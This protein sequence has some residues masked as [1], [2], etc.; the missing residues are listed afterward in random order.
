MVKEWRKPYSFRLETKKLKRKEQ[1]NTCANPDCDCKKGLEA[2]HLLP[3]SVARDIY[4]NLPPQAVRDINNLL[5]LCRE[6]HR[7]VH[8]ELRGKP[9]Q[10]E[11]LYYKAVFDHLIDTLGNYMFN[12]RLKKY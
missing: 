8:N 1:K 4:P 2:H 7:Q 5:Y 3:C 6:C 11:L 10:D 12:N 9:R